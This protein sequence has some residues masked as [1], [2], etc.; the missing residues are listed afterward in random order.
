MT[1]NTPDLESD[2]PGGGDAAEPE[3]IWPGQCLLDL[4]EEMTEKGQ[5]EYFI[6]SRVQ[7]SLMGNCKLW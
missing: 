3:R 6:G 7:S 2:E 5:F 4:S 1:K